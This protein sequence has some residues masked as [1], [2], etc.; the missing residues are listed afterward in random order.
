MNYLLGF[1]LGILG[2][3]FLFWNKLISLKLAKF[4]SNQ[5]NLHSKKIGDSLGWTNPTKPFNLFLCRIVVVFV[6]IFLL[7]LALHLFFG[8][9][10]I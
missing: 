5:F 1:I 6:A 7:I 4:Y 3:I 2:F 9:L 10:F 8:T